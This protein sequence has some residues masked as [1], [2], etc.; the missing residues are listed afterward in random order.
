MSTRAGVK[1]HNSELGDL[2]DSFGTALKVSDEVEPEPESSTTGTGT[3]SEDGSTAM[4]SPESRAAE[5]GKG[6]VPEI[7]LTSN[8]DSEQDEAE[9][10][11]AGGDGEYERELDLLLFF[12]PDVDDNDN[13]N[14]NENQVTEYQYWS[15][16]V[17]QSRIQLTEECHTT[18][19]LDELTRHNTKKE[20]MA[21]WAKS[22]EDDSQWLD[23]IM[24]QLHNALD[25][26][27][28][29]TGLSLTHLTT[30]GT[31]K[32]VESFRNSDSLDCFTEVLARQARSCLKSFYTQY[33][34]PA[35]SVNYDTLAGDSGSA[36][37]AST[38]G[39]E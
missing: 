26:W 31:V 13:D 32:A 38:S 27:K 24:D 28:A 23:G 25:D 6:K 4:T 22:A 17:L 18:L 9:G 29:E 3:D 10:E 14:D 2:A 16:D 39:A 30:K 35:E 11:E 34:P 37:K 36:A 7:Y 8:T 19:L 21:A 12:R 1:L 33:L 20:A 5:E 15:L